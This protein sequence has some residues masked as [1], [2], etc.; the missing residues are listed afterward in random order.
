VKAT[1]RLYAKASREYQQGRLD[2]AFEIGDRLLRRAPRHAAAWG[3][4]A[5]IHERR[6]EL[7]LAMERY[8]RAVELAPSDPALRNNLGMA[9]RA[10][11]RP[12]E[13]AESFREALA[14]RADYHLA[15][16]NLGL[17]ELDLNQA[18]A[19]VES[20]ERALRVRPDYAKARHNLGNALCR[21]GRREEGI[22]CM[23]EAL[24]LEPLYPEA[25]NSLGAALHGM[26]DLAG[27]VAALRRAL[28]IRPHYAKA[29][30]NLGNALA[31]VEE[32]GEALAAYRQA[33]ALEP[34]YRKALLALASLLE[35]TGQAEAAVAAA[36]EAVAHHPGAAESHLGLA[37]VLRAAG[38]MA[39][40]LESFEGA[41]ALDPG[42]DGARAGRFELRAELCDWA[43]RASDSERLE[44]ATEEALGRGDVPPVSASLCHRVLP[45][46]AEMQQRIARA[47]ASRME[48]RLAPLRHSLAFTHPAGR[49]ER[50]RV[51]YL[52]CDFRN[53]AVGHLTRGLFGLHDRARFEAFAYSY[54]PDD[55]SLYRKSVEERADRFMDVAQLS[56]A[57][58]ARRI[59]A[60]GIHVLVDLVG[61]AGNGRLEI[62][63]L[64]PAPIQVHFVGYPATTGASFIDYFIADAVV[65]PAG[66]ER[67]FEERVVRLPGSY[68]IN[69]HEQPIAGARV[70][71]ADCGLPV[72]GFVFCCFNA[73]YK[74]DPAIFDVWMR[75]LRRVPGS[76][77]W[78]LETQPLCAENLRREAE[79]R[80]VAGSRLVF[81]RLAPKPEHLDRHRLAGLFLD[82][83]LCNAHTTASDALWA[84]VPV[85]TC[86]GQTFASRVAASLLS[87]VR[88]PELIVPGLAEYEERAV[89]LATRPEELAPLRERLVRTRHETP[90]FDTPRFV[91]GLERAYETMLE[92]HDAG[93][94]PRGFDVPSS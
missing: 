38:R 59:H 9:L 37:Q 36:R 42:L 84:G 78:L 49:R 45:S 27:A 79:A 35:R 12:A 87:A 67:C 21:V 33:L 22:A 74:I 68:Q 66:E 26:G 92:I 14:L 44:R 64:R 54:G 56:H 58:A 13:A 70:S 50:V 15:F 90:L 20:F 53:N 91:R 5:A 40:A 85:L 34:G 46:T 77:L 19:A 82:T 63:A 30:L 17:A 1:E 3:L 6:G 7:G 86:P 73:P 4:L 8:R 93:E 48:A 76:V 57:E 69:D 83:P 29:L 72:D 94:P 10:A 51:G 65:V 18:A 89:R 52:S 31:D 61:G 2:A 23:R 60:D 75:V 16:N 11:G 55:G 24:R 25:L 28:Q 80:G 41:L 62:L 88:L 32:H 47:A 39:E 71:R 81:A 43:K